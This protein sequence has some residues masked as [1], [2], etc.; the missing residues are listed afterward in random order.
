MHHGVRPVIRQRVLN[1]DR[2]SEVSGKKGRSRIDRRAVTFD[3]IVEDADLVTL[4]QQH[5]GADA[6]DIT[7]APNNKNPHPW[8]RFA[9]S[10]DRSIESASLS[11]AEVLFLERDYHSVH[12]PML[13]ARCKHLK[14]FL[15]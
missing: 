8:K 12:R 15:G 3:Q 2:V 10:N 13:R 1:H 11:S 7:S 4:I 6:S 9:L 5:L 14:A